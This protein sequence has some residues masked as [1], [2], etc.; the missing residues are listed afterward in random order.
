[1]A[2]ILLTLALGAALLA[3]AGSASAATPRPD[4]VVTKVTHTGGLSVTVTTKNRGRRTAGASRTALFLSRDVV[5]DTADLRLG[6]RAVRRLKAGRS[7]RATR[8]GRIPSAVAA[9]T[10]VLLA[11]AD[12]RRKVR[13][14][15]ERNNCKL[16][17]A[18]VIVAA[19]GLVV[20]NGGGPGTTAPAGG[21]GPTGSG[22]TPGTGTTG[23]TGQTGGGGGGTTPAPRVLVSASATPAEGGSIKAASSAPG[24]SCSVSACSVPKGGEVALSATPATGYRFGGWAGDPGCTAPGRDLVV[25]ADSGKSCVASFVRTAT[26]QGVSGQGG[27][28]VVDAA[29]A[30]ACTGTACVLD[31]GNGSATFRAVPAANRRFGGWSGPAGCAA[32]SATLTV[33][34]PEADLVCTAS[35]VPVAQVSVAAP[36]NGLVSVSAKSPTTACVGLACRVD[37]VAGAFVEYVASPATGYR[38]AGWTGASCTGGTPGANTIRFTNP[39]G[40]KACTAVFHEIIPVTGKANTGGTVTAASSRNAD[41]NCQGT[42]TSRTCLLDKVD[43]SVTFVANSLPDHRFAGWSGCEGASIV[44][45][46]SNLT[47]SNPQ[48]ELTCTASFVPTVTLRATAAPSNGGTVSA[49]NAA[50][51]EPD[52]G[53][54][55]TCVLDAGAGAV[56]FTATPAPGQAFKGWS[57]TTCTGGTTSGNQITFANPSAHKDC[58]ATFGF[59]L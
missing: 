57:G 19:G 38:F 41:A 8:T 3:P 15:S 47:I 14:A 40:D 27:S 18:P 45:D 30:G 51:C 54:A 34:N 32:D 50:A 59:P 13:E 9:G 11:C 24:A 58:T 53:S 4:L 36:A 6:D 20:G 7:A 2:R 5:R 17:K 22:S 44:I 1:M 35:F 52:S 10:Y 37:Q 42:G 26:V 21:T 39:S 49:N 33:T 55:V 12:D 43:S 28:V 23:S 48:S 29:P 31:A 46:Q 25:T 16:A 56:T